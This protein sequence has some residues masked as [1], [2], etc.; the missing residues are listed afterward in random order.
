MAVIPHGPDGAQVHEVYEAKPGDFLGPR[1]TP[2]KEVPKNHIHK[3]EDYH[4]RQ[5]KGNENFDGL[6]KGI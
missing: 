5:K 1:K 4:D 6:E 2:A 3:D